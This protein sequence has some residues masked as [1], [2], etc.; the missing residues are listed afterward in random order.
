M[1]ANSARGP[2]WSATGSSGKSSPSSTSSSDGAPPWFGP[3][4]RNITTGAV[5]EETFRP[6]ERFPRARIEKVDV[7]FLYRDGQH[8]VVMDTQSFDQYPV[9]ESHF[10]EAAQY[11]K[12]S[13]HLFVLQYDG[14][15]IGVELPITVEHEVAQTDPGF[16]GDT[17]TGESKPATLDTGLVVDVPL[18]VETGDR[19]KVDTGP[20]STWS[21]CS[22]HLA[23][24]PARGAAAGAGEGGQRGSRLDCRPGRAGRSWDRCHARADWRQRLP[25]PAPPACPPAGS[26]YSIGDTGIKL[27]LTPSRLRRRWSGGGELHTRS[28]T[29]STACLA[30]TRWRS[31]C[32]SPK[33]RGTEPVAA[34]HRARELAVQV[35]FQLE[36]QPGSW[37]D[38]LQ[39]HL[40]L[41]PQSATNERFAEELVEGAVGHASEIDEMIRACSTNWA[42]DQ[43]GAL[44]RAVLRS[45][46]KSSAG[47]RGRQLRWSSTRPSSWPNR[48]LVR[49]RGK[50]STGFW[51]TWRA[52]PAPVWSKRVRVLQVGSSPR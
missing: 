50:S 22:E 39:Y 44:E 45:P 28:P 46:P 29:P 20:A 14:K 49:R 18:F 36:L 6:E 27:D 7:Q 13:H 1:L 9:D 33:S 42:L 30:W 38:P 35:L 23:A 12:E 41:E 43:M 21:G 3:G 47:V 5:T 15:V 10:T 26:S 52:A 16:K 34:R 19:L 51:A 17:A 40:D 11:V 31:I 24:E 25:A 4:F 2:P 48:W 8:Y 37:R 32:I